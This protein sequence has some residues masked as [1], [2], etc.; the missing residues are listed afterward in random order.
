MF[1]IV[2]SLT[3]IGNWTSDDGTKTYLIG[4]L[5][6][7]FVSRLEDKIRCFLYKP[8][9]NGGWKVAQSSEPSCNQLTSV[10]EGF[11]TMHLKKGKVKLFYVKTPKSY[12]ETCNKV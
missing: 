9:K 7:A 12:V 3:C 10:K 11:R 8:T 4:S 2:E 6:V 1:A 5:D